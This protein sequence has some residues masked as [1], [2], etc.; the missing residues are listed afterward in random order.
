MSFMA[1]DLMIGVLP[2]MDDRARPG[3]QLCGEVTRDQGEE[4]GE[5]TRDQVAEV[6]AEANLALLQ[7]Q[8]RQ[9]L[10]R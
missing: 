10:R 3:L 7:D 6:V 2:E 4:C 5:A 8:L 9:A 1:R